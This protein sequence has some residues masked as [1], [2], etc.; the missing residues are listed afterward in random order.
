MVGNNGA[1]I[2][3]VRANRICR[4]CRTRH[5]TGKLAT[6]CCVTGGDPHRWVET[7]SGRCPD[8]QNGVAGGIARGDIRLYQF[9]P[10]DKKRPV[11]VLTRDSVM[12]RSSQE[13]CAA[14]GQSGGLGGHPGGNLA[15]RK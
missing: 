4:S 14:C 7:A 12:S 13:L 8:R 1:K 2:L 3:N 10:P 11:V 6:L 9:A 15:L 5:E